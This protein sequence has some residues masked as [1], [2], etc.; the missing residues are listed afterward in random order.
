MR[1][2]SRSRARGLALA[3]VATA[4]GLLAAASVN[5]KVEEVESRTG[6]PVEVVVAARD[7][8]PGVRLARGRI[9]RTLT[10]REVPERYAPRDGLTARGQAV[11]LEA[12]VPI[13]LGAYVTAPMLRDPRARPVPVAPMRQGERLVEVAVSGGRELAAAGLPTRVDVLV[14]T[15]GHTGRGRTFVALE[16]V[17][18]VAAHAAG[19]GAAADVDGA[20]ADTIATLRVGTRAAVFLTAAQ[21]FAREVRLLARPPGDR[22]RIGSAAVPGAGLEP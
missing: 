11:G 13:P 1:S 7:I 16:D 9:A 19:A 5:D 2:P 14:T 17:E 8:G 18:V 21:N 3:F 6:R 22:G 4:C 12:A 15:E 10:L 20:Q